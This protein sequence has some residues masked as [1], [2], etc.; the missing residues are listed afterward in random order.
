MV[1][2]YRCNEIKL[3]AL[4]LV[5]EGVSSLRKKSETAFLDDF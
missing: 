3:E 4:E 5:G 2:N 1:A